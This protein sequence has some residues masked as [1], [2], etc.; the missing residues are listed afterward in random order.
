MIEEE[1]EFMMIM[2]CNLKVTKVENFSNINSIV[3]SQNMLHIL[4]TK[5]YR[6]KIEVIHKEKW[7]TTSSHPYLLTCC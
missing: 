4:N 6:K 2:I 5:P 7:Q 1:E 3:E